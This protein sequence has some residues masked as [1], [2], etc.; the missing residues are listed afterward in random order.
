ME[1][2]MESINPIAVVFAILGALISLFVMKNVEVN[3]IF[4][5]LTPIATFVACYII[6]SFQ[7]RD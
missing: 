5:I 6:T 4:K 1:F 7:F 2:D 3:M